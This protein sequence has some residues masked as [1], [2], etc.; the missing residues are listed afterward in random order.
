MILIPKFFAIIFDRIK[1][2]DL[3]QKSKIVIT[4]GNVVINVKNVKKK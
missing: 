4:F 1:Y 3:I 2:S